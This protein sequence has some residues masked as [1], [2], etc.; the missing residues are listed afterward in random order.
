MNAAAAWRDRI[1]GDGRIPAGLKQ[2]VAD[3]WEMFF[4]AGAVAGVS[5]SA[6][7]DAPP[8]WQELNFLAC[9]DGTVRKVDQWTP[10]LRASWMPD[11]YLYHRGLAIDRNGVRTGNTQPVLRGDWFNFT[12]VP[13]VGSDTAYGP[14]RGIGLHERAGNPWEITPVVPA[15]PGANPPFRRFCSNA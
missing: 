4:N 13:E 11:N 2:L 14:C 3:V 10:I 7:N 12:K 6:F 15:D 1:D 9:V 5:A 8:I